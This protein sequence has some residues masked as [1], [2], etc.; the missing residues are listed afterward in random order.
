MKSSEIVQKAKF[1]AD[2]KTIYI[3]G[4]KGHKM[5]QGMKLK[6]ASSD[7]FNAKRTKKIFDEDLKGIANIVRK[8]KGIYGKIP[9]KARSSPLPLTFSSL[10]RQVNLTVS[11]I[12][13]ALEDMV[14]GM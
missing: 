13:K 7:P 14:V 11:P 12:S 4:S 3:R 5:S 1:L 6:Y 9:S 10:P 2:Q 8:I